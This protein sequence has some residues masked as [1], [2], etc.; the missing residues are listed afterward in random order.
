MKPVPSIVLAA[1]AL[2]LAAC[3]DEDERMAE[4]QYRDSEAS[5]TPG[6]PT[7]DPTTIPPRTNPDAPVNPD[8]TLPPNIP[9]ADTPPTQN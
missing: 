7:P 5:T 6:Y 8:G 1:G 3:S 4:S 2:V 9:P